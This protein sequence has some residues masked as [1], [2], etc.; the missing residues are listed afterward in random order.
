VTI[1]NQYIRTLL[2]FA[3][4]NYLFLG[5]KSDNFVVDWNFLEYHLKQEFQDKESNKDLNNQENKSNEESEFLLETSK[6]DETFLI[7]LQKKEVFEIE[8]QEF[9]HN[10]EKTYN[11]VKALLFTCLLEIEISGNK[12]EEVL[13]NFTKYLRLS[14]DFIGSENVGLVHAVLMKIFEKHGVNAKKIIKNKN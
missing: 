6:L 2:F 10:W 13:P 4:Y 14:Q 11:L 7:Y 1:W 3:I 9:L 8:L 12:A 5:D